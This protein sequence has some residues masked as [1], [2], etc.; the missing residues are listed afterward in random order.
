MKKTMQSLFTGIL[1]G[2]LLVTGS[3]FAKSGIEAKNLSYNDIKITLNGTTLTPTDANG[4]RTEPFIIDGTTYLPVRAVAQA[5]GLFVGW[6]AETQ[7]VSLSSHAPTTNDDTASNQSLKITKTYQWNDGYH[8]IAFVVKN[9]SGIPVY[10]NLQI[11]FKDAAG[12]I[13]GVQEKDEDP[14][15]PG[16]EVLMMVSN[17]IP[18]ASYDCTLSAETDTSYVECLSY[19]QTKASRVQNKLILQVTNTGTATAEFVEYTVLFK[20]AG[21]VV[22]YDWGFCVDNDNELKPGMTQMREVSCYKDYDSFEIYLTGRA[23]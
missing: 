1:I 21:R 3:V 18:F 17:D 10:P 23:E 14:I 4:N 5:M 11:T 22:D 19:L 2:I 8:Y 20:K 16:S 7:T 6:N 9:V 12:N 15:A 13:V